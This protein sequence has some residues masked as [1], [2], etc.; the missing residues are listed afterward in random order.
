M[1]E[2]NILEGLL[3]LVV[4]GGLWYVGYRKGMYDAAVAVEKECNRI[5]IEE[6]RRKLA[7]QEHINQ[8]NRMKI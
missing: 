7:E 4:L 5:D 3:K 1:F 2:D 8:M 6:L